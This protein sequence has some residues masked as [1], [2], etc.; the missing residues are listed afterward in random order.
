MLSEG[1]GASG[2]EAGLARLMERQFSPLA[3]RVYADRF[4]NFYAE[5]LGSPG[6]HTVMLAAHMDEVGLIVTR[7]DDRGFIRF[8]DLIGIDPRTLLA[9]E[10]VIHGKQ[11]VLGVIGSMPPH[12]VQ[13]TQAGKAIKIED[14]G[15]DVGLSVAEIRE[16]V[17]VGDTITLKRQLQELL[18][19]V[20]A[21][22]ALDDRAGI[23]AMAVCL[24]ELDRMKFG[25]KVVAVATAQE[26]VHMRG[27]VVSTFALDP[28]IGIAIDVTFAAEANNKLNIELGKG[29]AIA[30]G[31]NIHPAIY[32]GLVDSAQSARLSYQLQPIPGRSGTDAWSMQVSRAGIPTGLVSVPLR[33]M[34]TCVET[35][36]VE[37]VV[38]TGKLLAYFI[39]TLPEDLEG[40]LCF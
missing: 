17:E 19:G 21:G 3:D 9:Q 27:S 23:A 5:K 16:V 28:E 7:I 26:E 11:E 29:P 38:S 24:E 1:H 10:V 34:H 20:V 32:R 14:M 15:I 36:S 39:A 6:K 33:Y 40:F 31:A 35:V 4:G 25:P 8:T 37:D 18:N 13:V 30:L 12:L 22:K 2:Y